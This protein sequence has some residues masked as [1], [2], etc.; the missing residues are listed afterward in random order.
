MKKLLFIMNTMGHAGAETALIELLNRI[1]PAEYE[2]SLFVVTAQGEMI[3]KL[4]D[5][6]RL[7]NST[8]KDVSVLDAEGRKN[9]KKTVIKSFFRRAN[10]VRLF[11]YLISNL[12]RMIKKGKILPD[13]LLWRV[14]SDGAERF[15]TEYDLAV[16]YLEG[17]SAY[18]LADHVK[19][20]KKAAFIHVDYDMA[21]Y[22]RQLDRNCYT[23]FDR[24][25]TVSEA[26]KVPFI[27]NYRECEAKTELFKNYIDVA[28]I[29]SKAEQNIDFDAGF[30][31]KRIVTV[32]RLTAPKALDISIDACE[33]LV[34][35]G[36]NIRWYVLGDGDMRKELENHIAEKHMEK[37]FILFG[38]V[39]N[40]FPF[41]RQADI[42]AHC[43]R[44]EGSSI[45]VREAQV[46]GKPML[47]T[48]CAGNLE[49]VED[50]RNGIVCE[51]NAESIAERLQLLLHDM[52]LCRRLGKAAEAS[53][54]LDGEEI[55]KL[56]SLLTA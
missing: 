21:G 36:E 5:S 20:V 46:L 27:R 49:L 6:V 13:K 37:Y 9:L 56:F 14:V 54:E 35:S 17:A 33:K 8:Y 3:S 31:G 4:P 28:G 48:N 47:V 34:K 7:I 23:S 42:Y 52:E 30:N 39:D 41:M 11:P 12:F 16:S 1:S 38:A 22:T 24:I 25:F 53:V 18:Y 40:P 45:A 10:F 29:L 51:L 32:G 43:S 15:D 2:V 19:A 50:G 55:Q 44:Y 26:V